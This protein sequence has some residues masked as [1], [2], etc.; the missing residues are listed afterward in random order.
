MRL[1]LI[2]LTFFVTDVAFADEQGLEVIC[3]NDRYLGIFEHH[4]VIDSATEQKQ[5]DGAVVSFGRHDMR[6]HVGTHEVKVKLTPLLPEEKDICAYGLGAFFDL[7]INNQPFINKALFGP[8]CFHGSSITSVEIFDTSDVKEKSFGIKICGSGA[9]AVPDYN[10]CITV[11]N[12]HLSKLP[13]PLSSPLAE[14]LKAHLNG[15]I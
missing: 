1:F 11:T 5:R 10:A 4:V 9:I 14:M 3:N 12:K 15:Q 2:I 8:G 7:E 13:T 6:C